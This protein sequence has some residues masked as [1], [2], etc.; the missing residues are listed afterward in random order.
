MIFS[1][2]ADLLAAPVFTLLFSTIVTTSPLE[3]AE[4]HGEA[5]DA[6][7]ILRRQVADP[8]NV[9]PEDETDAEIAADGTRPLRKAVTARSIYLDQ[10]TAT[11]YQI[12]V[13]SNDLAASFTS[14][15]D[16][17]TTTSIPPPDDPK[18]T[19]GPNPWN[20]DHIF[21][22]Q[23]I[24]EAFKADRPTDNPTSIAAADWTAVTNAVFTLSPACTAIAEEVTVLQNLEGIPNAV[25]SFKKQVFTGNLTGVGFPSTGNTATYYSFFGP[26][27]QN[28]LA[29]NQPNFFSVNG[30]VDNIGDQLSSAGNNNAAIKAYFTSYAAFHY[31]GAIDYLSTWSGKPITRT[32]ASS[33]AATGTSATTATVTCQ[34]NADPDNTCAAIA[35]SLGYCECNNDGNTYAIEPSAPNPC[36]WTTLPPTTSFDCSSTPPPAPVVVTP[37]TTPLACTLRDEVIGGG[38]DPEITH[39]CTCNDGS[40]PSATVSGDEYACPAQVSIIAKRSPWNGIDLGNFAQ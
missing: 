14:F 26:A 18:Q 40:S 5:N 27:V 38:R 20:V 16:T 32:I 6:L 37:T 12:D 15:T 19:S 24:G 10:A 3:Y 4:N 9:A 39:I 35:D 21:E 30:I 23:I 34:H 29:S 11:W 8:T 25:N 36:G 2:K 13:A 31:Q 33:T 22:L 17:T 1:S 28:Y 7:V